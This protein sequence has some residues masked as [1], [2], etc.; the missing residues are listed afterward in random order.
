MIPALAGPPPETGFWSWPILLWDLKSMAKKEGGGR[1]NT[2]YFQKRAVFA[3][4]LLASKIFQCR[5][6]LKR[7]NLPLAAFDTPNLGVLRMFGASAAQGQFILMWNFL[8]PQA[9]HCADLR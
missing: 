9:P 8:K 7:N 2:R 1:F 5:K 3:L 6:C 4:T